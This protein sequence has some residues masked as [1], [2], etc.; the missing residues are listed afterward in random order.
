MN[1][2]NH[3]LGKDATILAVAKMVPLGVSM[4]MAILLS[5]CLSLHDYGTYSQIMLLVNLA[6]AFLALGLPNSINYFVAKEKDFEKQSEYVSNYYVLLIILGG[7][8]GIALFFSVSYFAE[9]FKNSSLY[10]FGFAISS[11]PL[12]RLIIVSFDSYQVVFGKLRRLVLFKITLSLCTLLSVVI[13][14]IF[15][16]KLK[17]MMATICGISLLFA[18]L[19]VIE[20]LKSIKK[21]R[22]YFS[23][24]SIKKILNF[25]IPIWLATLVGTLSLQL[26]KLI[27]GKFYDTETLAI[28]VN[29]GRELPLTV[30]S[31]S[32]TAILLPRLTRLLAEN[33][34]DKAIE[35]WSKATFLSYIIICFIVTFILVNSKEVLTILYSSK[36]VAGDEVFK[37]YTL[38]LLL[39]S[40]YFGMI[41]SSIG[42]TKDIMYSSIMALILNIILSFVFYKIFGFVG[43]ALATLLAITFAAGFQLFRTAIYLEIKVLNVLLWKKMMLI[44]IA[45][46]VLGCT[47]LYFKVLFFSIIN[48]LYFYMLFAC[49]IWFVIGMLLYGRKVLYLY[50]DLKVRG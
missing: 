2:S 26:D 42:R 16:F 43:P 41:L 10:Q 28:Y 39:R 14:C 4:I 33:E 5:R 17:F 9:Y 19:S 24:R 7:L 49:G 1:K 12:L 22:L 45:N 35:L 47:W 37:I 13:T 20:V 11:L 34:K 36:F 30:I 6:V 31:A 3:N 18:W 15:A 32:L 46:M 44:S 25:S 48:N 40:T 38:V 8:G 23:S 27:I 29:A 21:V 50:N